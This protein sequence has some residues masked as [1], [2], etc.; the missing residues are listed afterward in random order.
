M[1]NPA[2]DLKQ[3]SDAELNEQLLAVRAD[4]DAAKLGRKKLENELLNRKAAE[5]KAAYDAK[6]E[7]FGV[8]NIISGGK[9][10]K[11]DIPK[12]IDWLQEELERIWKEIAAGGD[13]P[14]S[15]IKAEYTVSETLYK[16]FGDNQKKYFGV[17]R[18]VKSGNPSIK[19]EDAE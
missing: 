11:I 1:P 15:F 12:K 3:L 17:A 13:D 18:T 6:P 10:I 2:P 4:E 19:I 14:K 5:L 16:T 9:K 8:V 7:P